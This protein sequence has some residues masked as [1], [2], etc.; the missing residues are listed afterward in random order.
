LSH[1]FIEI[2]L[3][4]AL[5]SYGAILALVEGILWIFRKRILA[6]MEN[7]RPSDG[8]LAHLVLRVFP[9]L[10]ALMLTCISAVP[11]YF[12]GE[13]MRTQELPGPLLIG[14]GW[15]GLYAIASP[16]LSSI[17]SSVRTILRTSA[18]RKRAV[19]SERFAEIPV[20]EFEARRPVMV[21]SGLIRNI[22]F[23]SRPVR[24]LLSMREMRAALKHEV[25][26][27]RQ[28]HNL[29]KL[30]SGMMP[31]LISS[32]PLDEN[33][34][35]MIEYAAD[36]EACSTPGDALHLA[37]ALVIIARQKVSIPPQALYAPLIDSRETIRLKRRV[38][39]LVQ[40]APRSNG[41]IFS[42]LIATCAAIVA[43][44]S[45]VGAL[46]PAQHL[47]REGLELLVR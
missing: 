38:E 16:L 2:L 32:T 20:V 9:P 13:P 39:R 31:Q 47:F 25:A 22:I 10:L 4:Y 41:Q 37:S 18:W 44:V 14:L 27:C 19:G 26:H 5:A 24:P 3:L 33:L 42:E 6:M 46:P 11:G 28:H 30:L 21:A 35:E 17:A 15:L 1:R 12:T 45:F 8:I 36:D 40:I 23:V 29:A 43:V 7:L 34:R